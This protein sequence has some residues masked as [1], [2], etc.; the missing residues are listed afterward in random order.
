MAVLLIPVIGPIISIAMLT[1]APFIASIPIV[2]P[3]AAFFTLFV[4][5]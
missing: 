1:L 4:V 2:G 5:F 3:Y